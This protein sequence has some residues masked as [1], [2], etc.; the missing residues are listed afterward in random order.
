MK[1]NGA[2]FIS[3]KRQPYHFLVITDHEGTRSISLNENTY[4][5]GRDAKAGIQ[6]HD[7]SVSRHHATLRCLFDSDNKPFYNLID[8][9]LEGSRSK[10]GIEVN[11]LA[12]RSEILESGDVIQM[13]K[14]K[15]CYQIESLNMTE[16]KL[17]LSSIPD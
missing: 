9:D 12:C 4:I 17:R 6:I 14:A 3:T 2:I 10:N 15:I 1:K 8:G 7:Q 5:L 16:L 11:Q 13:G